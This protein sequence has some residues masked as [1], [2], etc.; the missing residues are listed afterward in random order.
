M[1]KQKVAYVWFDVFDPER[2]RWM[3]TKFKA[4]CFS[5]VHE[6]GNV[7]EYKLFKVGDLAKVLG[8]TSGTVRVWEDSGK[9]PPPR[10]VLDD[11]VESR[12]NKGGKVRWYSEEQIRMMSSHQRGILGDDPRAAKGL[13]M[14]IEQFFKAVKEDWAI[15]YFDED[16]YEYVFEEVVKGSKNVHIQ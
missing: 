14:N 3:P 2:K 4:R 12:Y 16:E 10:F 1:S 8:R 13:A 6:N 11:S 15:D 9:I 7:K 5:H